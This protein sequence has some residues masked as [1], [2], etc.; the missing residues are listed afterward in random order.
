MEPFCIVCKDKEKMYASK[1]HP[2]L[3]EAHA[4]AQRLANIEGKPFLLFVF[5]ERVEPEVAFVAPV[6]TRGGA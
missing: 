3:D 2:T 1:R 4:E 5:A 6:D